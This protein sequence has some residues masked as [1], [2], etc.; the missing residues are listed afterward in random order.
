[1]HHLSTHN[2]NSNNYTNNNSIDVLINSLN[3]EYMTPLL[4]ACMNGY[5]D[6]LYILLYTTYI[7]INIYNTYTN[8]S[9]IMYTCSYNFPVCLQVL[10]D[11]SIEYKVYIDYNIQCS[12]GED[13][14][15]TALHLAAKE[16]NIECINILC[17]ITNNTQNS[18]N[19]CD[20]SS[21]SICNIDV[22]MT[23]DYN[24]TALMYTVIYNY[25]DC[26]YALLYGVYNTPI[27]IHAL[28]KDGKSARDLAEI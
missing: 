25:P 7:N 21:N 23:D 10:I 28:D 1:M 2:N 22:N 20:K 6:I 18:D 27:D 9:A 19:N 15:C 17:N 26:M 11:Y 3:N 16:G 14:G 4:I 5:D 8:W 24:R 12:T 13:K